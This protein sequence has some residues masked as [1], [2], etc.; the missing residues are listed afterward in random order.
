MAACWRAWA[1]GDEDAAE[2]AYAAFLP[3]ALFGMQSLE[4]LA[5][6]GKRV[7]GLR[8]GIAIH[9]RAPAL[10]PGE[11]GLRLAARWAGA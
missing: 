5:A 9:D 10:R 7:F 3:G 11:A 4:H 1:A 8:A 6:Y 2:T